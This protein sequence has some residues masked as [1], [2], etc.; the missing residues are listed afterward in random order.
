MNLNLNIKLTSVKNIKH[1]NKQSAFA[2]NNNN[3]N[4][5][6]INLNLHFNENEKGKDEYKCLRGSFNPYLND[7]NLKRQRLSSY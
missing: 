6:N 4:R 3:K 5:I 7:D 1:I 2:P